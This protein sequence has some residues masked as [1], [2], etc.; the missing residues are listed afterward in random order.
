MI[1][2]KEFGAG[3]WSSDY[4]KHWGKEYPKLSYSK[5]LGKVVLDNTAA[6]WVAVMAVDDPA[7][8]DGGV[9]FVV[10]EY[11]MEWFYK[12][13]GRKNPTVKEVN[14]VVK[15]LVQQANEDQKHLEQ[16]ATTCWIVP[17]KGT[18][19][20]GII[21]VVSK[22]QKAFLKG[23]PDEIRVWDGRDQME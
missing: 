13:T 6:F 10:D 20:H 8:L 23:S 15:M 18:N 5:K 11:F 9:G 17:A 12:T 2:K 3:W 1:D 14:H 16:D 21:P 19:H 7:I 22:S 4:E